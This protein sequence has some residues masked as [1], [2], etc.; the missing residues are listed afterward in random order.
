MTPSWECHPNFIQMLYL[1]RPESIK[2][3][4]SNVS[5][6]KKSV[7]TYKLALLQA[8]SLTTAPWL[9]H[10][11]LTRLA[12]D[13]LPRKLFSLSPTVLELWAE[14]YSSGRQTITSP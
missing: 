11:R 12:P 4:L 9:W 13:M 6:K 14:L 5:A 10:R 2:A 3:F 8:L 7:G 1:V